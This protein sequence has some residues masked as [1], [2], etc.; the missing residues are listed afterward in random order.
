MLTSKSPLGTTPNQLLFWEDVALAER[1][2][3]PP[4]KQFYHIIRGFKQK[5]K[6]KNNSKNMLL[7]KPTPL[8]FKRQPWSDDITL[9]K[10]MNT[11]RPGKPAKWQL[12]I[13]ARP[14]THPRI[15]LA[16]DKNAFQSLSNCSSSPW[17]CWEMPLYVRGTVLT[18]KV[19]LCLMTHL[20]STTT[21]KSNSR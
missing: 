11:Q 14:A 8:E 10:N 5:N 16:T 1:K 9:T 7:L 18:H 13:L 4:S 2:R 15:I 6:S 20:H 21:L 12:S 17:V 3:M 19:L